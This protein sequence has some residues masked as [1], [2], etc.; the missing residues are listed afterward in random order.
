[1]AAAKNRAIEGFAVMLQE[2]F[3][4]HHLRQQAQTSAGHEA[5]V[6]DHREIYHALRAKDA[7]LATR[8]MREHFATYPSPEPVATPD[9]ARN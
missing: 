9:A 6:R 5:S 1:M 3:H 8:L 7:E 2:F 4:H